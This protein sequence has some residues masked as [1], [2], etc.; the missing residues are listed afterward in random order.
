MS[1]EFY[2]NMCVSHSQKEEYYEC[3]PDNNPSPL[4]KNRIITY[5]KKYKN[6]LTENE[7]L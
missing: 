1:P 2:L 6:S 5:T 7:K 4:L 3:I